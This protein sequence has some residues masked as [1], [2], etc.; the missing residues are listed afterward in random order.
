MRIFGKLFRSKNPGNERVKSYVICPACGKTGR[1][2]WID[3]IADIKECDYC[4]YAG[5]DGFE[6]VASPPGTMAVINEV[7]EC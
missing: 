6:W 5:R 4:E 3:V 2:G 1:P 7:A